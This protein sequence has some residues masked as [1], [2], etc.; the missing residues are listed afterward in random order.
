MEDLVQVANIGLLKSIDA[1]DPDRGVRFSTL[2]AATMLGELKRHFRDAAWA[3]HVP[4]R[5]KEAALAAAKSATE[6][7]SELGREPT[8][9]EIAERAG[10][11]TEE[12]LNGL[13]AFAAYSTEPLTP[14]G[15]GSLPVVAEEDPNLEIAEGWAQIADGLQHLSDRERRILYLR[16]FADM[17]QS[18][19]AREVGISQ[20]H[21]SRTLSIVLSDLRERSRSSRPQSRRRQP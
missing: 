4:R 2:A 15:E 21:V 14:V 10:L 6:L 16:F 8:M 1:F 7:R 9:G 20:M 17:S 3:L 12:A 18:E 5:Q 19:I 13:D 11:T